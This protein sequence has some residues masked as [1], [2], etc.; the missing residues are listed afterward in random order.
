MGAWGKS[1][2]FPFHVWLPDA[3][4]GPTPVSA[5]IHSATMVVAGV[6][7]TARLFPLFAAAEHTLQ[8]V[9]F[10]GA[11]TAV[12]AAAVACTQTDLKRILAFSTLS[13]LGL[14]MLALGVSIPTVANGGGGAV[15]TIANTAG[16]TAALFHVFTH[17]FFKSLL[18]LSAGVIIHAIHSNDLRDAGGLRKKMPWT[19]ISTLAA[20][21]ALAGLWPFAG[22]FSKEEILGVALGNGHF[23]FVAAGLLTGGLTAFY[24][25][26][27]FVLVF[28]GSAR[29]HASSAMNADHAGAAHH[30]PTEPLLMVLPLIVLTVPSVLVG[31]LGRNA[32]LKDMLPWTS[33]A[34]APV[35]HLEAHAGFPWMVLVATALAL[36]GIGTGLYLYGRKRWTAGYAD[37]RGPWLYR[38]LRDKLYVDEVYSFLIRKVGSRFVITPADWAERKILNASFDQGGGVLNKLARG[39][40]R[41]QNGQVQRSVA[42]A[43]LGL[44]LLLALYFSGSP[45]PHLFG[46]LK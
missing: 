45:L 6:Y 14:M 19:Y 12:F 38:I 16:Y 44:V 46:S 30:G 18:F 37:D 35:E 42:T 2:M 11:L 9:A 34:T 23:T 29:T 1:A 21:L 5:L 17:A 28:H 4:E 27:Y 24:M 22:F 3:M 32:F 15:T 41:Y 13:Q 31:W 39:L 20:C 40:S 43:L 7:L 36:S 10:T 26:R 33:S 8:L 25:T